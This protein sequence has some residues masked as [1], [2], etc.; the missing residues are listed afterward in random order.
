MNITGGYL[1][2]T[3]PSGDT[4]GIDSNGSITMSGGVVI[5]RSG[6]QMGGVAGSVDVDGTV[7]VTG[8][9]I[10]AL[11]GICEVPEGDSVNTYVS[12]TTSF[13]AGEY[14]VSD[15]AGSTVITFSL[16]SSYSSFWIASDNIALNGGYKLTKDNSVVLEWN[17]SS[18]LVGYSGGG[19]FGPGGG[20]RP[21]RR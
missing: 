1:D 18:Q 20:F 9:T 4:D 13:S 21:G 5:V 8:G 15:S 16:P 3:T 11:G 17:Q 19:G 10:V 12:S 7:T 6:A 14:T 2:V